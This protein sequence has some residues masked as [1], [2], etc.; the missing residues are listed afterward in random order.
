MIISKPFRKFIL[1]TSIYINKKDDFHVILN[2]N[3]I[4]FLKAGKRT[5][6][7]LDI[8]VCLCRAQ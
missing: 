2:L 6:P 8:S 7:F 4:Q 5:R 3:T 1:H